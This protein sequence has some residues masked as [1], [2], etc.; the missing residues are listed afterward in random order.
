MLRFSEQGQ[1]ANWYDV[2][3]KWQRH[4]ATYE[5]CS[6]AGKTLYAIH[7]VETIVLDT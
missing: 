5:R 4:T 3:P 7:R 1:Y 6:L 2:I